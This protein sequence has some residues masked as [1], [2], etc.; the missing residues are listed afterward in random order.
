MNNAN[1]NSYNLRPLTN[2]S[3]LKKFFSETLLL[4]IVRIFWRIFPK[5]ILHSREL[6]S[7]V[8]PPIEGMMVDSI[9]QVPDNESKIVLSFI[10]S[11]IVS[12]KKQ[13][14]VSENYL[15]ETDWKNIFDIQ[16]DKYYKAIHR[17]VLHVL[18]P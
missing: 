12:K 3:V 18:K 16:R 6:L 1:K 10:N 5:R 17:Q 7:P 11:F 4:F 2:R 14:D 15:P 9:E 13:K 8:T